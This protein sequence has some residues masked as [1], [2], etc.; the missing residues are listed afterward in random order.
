M[1]IMGWGRPGPLRCELNLLGRPCG[2]RWV[3]KDICK[4]LPQALRPQGVSRTFYANVRWILLPGP[5]PGAEAVT[6][7]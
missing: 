1:G 7:Y 3:N 5:W 6:P 2:A 4:A